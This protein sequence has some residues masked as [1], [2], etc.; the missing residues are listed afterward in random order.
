V[1]ASNAARF[2]QSYR[3]IADR[4]KVRGRHDPK[5]NI[6]KLVHDW[7]CDSARGKW[8]LILDN[9]DDASFLLAAQSV[10]KRGQ[11]HDA[12]SSDLQPLL[13]YLP[14]SQNGSIL[15]TT[16][17][18]AAALELVE[19]SD[20]VAVPP[21]DE[22]QALA[23]L[24]KKLKTHLTSN[25]VRELAIAL[26]YMP[27][28]IVQAAAYIAQRAPRC[29]VHQ[30]LKEFQRSDREKTTLLDHKAGRLRRD[31]E[32]KNSIIITWQMSFDHI[33]RIR[34]SAAELLSLMSFFDRQGIPETL[35]RCQEKVGEVSNADEFEDDLHM[36]RS[37]SFVAVDDDGVTFEM[38]ALVQ[39][40]MRQ[41]LENNGQLEKWKQ[42]YINNLCTAFPTTG[43]HKNWAQCQALFPHPSRRCCSRPSLRNPLNSGLY[44]CTRR[45]GM[46]GK[47]EV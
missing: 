41:W 47:K 5:A 33:R 43:E 44:C 1:H 46:R 3:D 37:Y 18:R 32:A 15:I 9:V 16:R 11:K 30:Y 8:V 45:R 36:L 38:H 12:D 34:Q 13:M 7:L 26:E 20:I 17:T 28:A 4:L 19:E 39:L 6:F 35:L 27:L 29:S 14:Q 10:E 22:P 21:M 23:L 25:R 24:E 42:Q 31:R 2:E 40:A